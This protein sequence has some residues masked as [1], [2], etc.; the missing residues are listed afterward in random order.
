M[1]R[2][3]EFLFFLLTLALALA[4]PTLQDTSQHPPSAATAAKHAS[5]TDGND[6]QQTSSLRASPRFE[7]DDTQSTSLSAADGSGS[8]SSGANSRPSSKTHCAAFDSPRQSPYTCSTQY[9]TCCEI[10]SLGGD[11]C[12]C[13]AGGGSEGNS[14][15]PDDGHGPGGPTARE[16]TTPPQSVAGR[17]PPRRRRKN[18]RQKSKSRCSQTSGDES[19]PQQEPLQQQGMKQQKQQ[20]M[21]EWLALRA[22]AV[23]CIS[24]PG[25]LLAGA[26]PA[27]QENEAQR[28]SGGATSARAPPEQPTVNQSSEES[29]GSRASSPCSAH[30]SERGIDSEAEHYEASSS[31]PAAQEEISNPEEG[32]PST[33]PSED[34]QPESVETLADDNKPI[35]VTPPASRPMMRFDPDTP[36]FTSA[37]IDDTEEVTTEVESE[38]NES[39]ALAFFPSLE[40]NIHQPHPHVQPS[41]PY[42]ASPCLLLAAPDARRA[43]VCRV[44]RQHRESVLLALLSDEWIPNYI[45]LLY[46]QSECWQIPRTEVQFIHNVFYEYLNDYHFAMHTQELCL[47]VWDIQ[48][49]VMLPGEQALAAEWVDEIMTQPAITPLQQESHRRIRRLQRVH[50]EIKEMQL[51]EYKQALRELL[52]LPPMQPPCH[53]Q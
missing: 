24:K 21:H 38:Q 33:P 42:F 25:L 13:A 9:R 11:S 41:M 44:V 2:L 37:P 15:K 27:T 17:A 43:R 36:E 47:G 23:L 31:G 46:R 30:D 12:L 40:S 51:E 4:A 53:T 6:A 32:A 52:R 20:Q 35:A 28:T 39:L 19:N 29:S 50:L 26:R 34:N 3:R 49:H 8:F 7:A 22:I 16:Q 10:S 45:G 14:S 18:K 5:S 48:P 1:T